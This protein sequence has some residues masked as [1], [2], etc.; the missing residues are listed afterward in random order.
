M[1]E[2][3]ERPPRVKKVKGNYVIKFQGQTIKIKSHLD[4][5]TTVKYVKDNL[6]NRHKRNVKKVKNVKP[7]RKIAQSKLKSMNE[8]LNDNE[9][10][11]RSMPLLPKSN[12]SDTYK[13]MVDSKINELTR[14]NMDLKDKRELDLKKQSE[15]LTK[16]NKKLQDERDELQAAEQKL[17]QELEALEKQKG[18]TLAEYEHK[19]TTITEKYE[20]KKQRLIDINRKYLYREAIDSISDKPPK[21][22]VMQ[23]LF[24]ANKKLLG[25]DGI[26]SWN[27]IPKFDS[28]LERV[29]GKGNIG[30][31]LTEQQREHIV[32]LSSN[33]SLVYEYLISEAGGTTNTDFNNYAFVP[34]D[35]AEEE[36]PP[37]DE[38]N[39]VDSNNE[40]VDGVSSNGIIDDGKGLY[41]YQIDEVMKKIMPKE[42]CGVYSLDTVKDVKPNKKHETCIIFNNQKHNQ[43]GEHWLALLI[44][45]FDESVEFYDSFGNEP[46][47]ELS[48]QINKIMKK[49]NPDTYYKFKINRIKSQGRSSNCGYFCEKFLIDRVINNKPFKEAS[50][51]SNVR[52]GEKQ[53]E[54]FKKSKVFEYI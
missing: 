49:L 10:T 20:K 22:K 13:Q 39:N 47:K 34:V 1:K 44:S 8:L 18:L 53:I 15:A 41:D 5:K 45:P 2:L 28:F 12:E 17:K 52:D 29:K 43:K 33:P 46:P 26:T 14:Q 3:I 32:S 7:K 54:K 51:I 37:T 9:K 25:Y 30:Q 27:N 4:K 38:N 16:T 42:W 36:Q 6:V 19:Y 23:S 11:F 50:V 24:N 48:K 31:E 40:V 21:T 35:Y